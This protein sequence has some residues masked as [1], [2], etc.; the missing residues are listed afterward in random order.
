MVESDT[1]SMSNMT[2]GK[3]PRLP[4]VS[5]KNAILGKKYS[6][7]LSFLTPGEQKKLNTKY[8]GK[9]K[10]TTVLSFSLSKT[11]GEITFDLV[12][13]KRSAPEF[14]MTYEKF[15]KY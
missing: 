2:K 7:S 9:H 11:S 13:V 5:I 12:E 10:S 1:F 4:F 15:L 14:D 6:L 8:R 3:L